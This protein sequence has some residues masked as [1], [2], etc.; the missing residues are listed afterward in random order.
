MNSL[1]ENLNNYSSE[2]LL[3]RRALGDQLSDEAHQAI[4]KILI[5]RNVTLPPIPKESIDVNNNGF[6]GGEK[7]KA[8]MITIILIADLILLIISGVMGKILAKTSIG[9][10]FFVISIVLWI[11]YFLY[12]YFRKSNLNPEQK[13]EE[14]KIKKIESEKITDLMLASAEGNFDRAMDLISYGANINNVSKNG[15]TALM[16]ASKNGHV[17][18]VKLLLKNDA[19]KEIINNK[20]ST[21]LSLSKSFNRHEVTEYLLNNEN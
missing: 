14:E 5:E 16:Y 8:S 7:K 18:I 19:D 13:E 20:G 12:E 6:T 9:F 15:S 2:Y 1:I 17:D 11:C 10:Y 21:A 4:E 3:G